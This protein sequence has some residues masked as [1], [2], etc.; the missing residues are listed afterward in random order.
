VTGLVTVT[1]EILFSQPGCHLIPACLLCLAFPWVPLED[2]YG[3]GYMDMGMDLDMEHGG[4]V[5]VC[6]AG[7]CVLCSVLCALCEAKV[8]RA[9]CS[10]LLAAGRTGAS[11]VIGDW[12]RRWRIRYRSRS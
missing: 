7:L 1:V 8:V 11:P 3:Y 10:S 6:M 2:G 12:G 5:S 9:R 4:F